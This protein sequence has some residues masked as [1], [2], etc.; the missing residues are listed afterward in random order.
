MANQEF[1][2]DVWMRVEGTGSGRPINPRVT[3][4]TAFLILLSA[5]VWLIGFSL[6]GGAIAGP[7]ERRYLADIIF[8]IAFVGFFVIFLAGFAVWARAKGYSPLLGIVLAWI[9]PLG[10]LIMVFLKDK[11]RE[12]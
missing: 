7:P 4:K 3:L 12:P 1:G 6:L 5:F 8:P 2:E 10:M 9:G 11:T